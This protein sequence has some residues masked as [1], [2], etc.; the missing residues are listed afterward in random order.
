MA[1]AKLD[2]LFPNPSFKAGVISSQS[3]LVDFSPF[4]ITNLNLPQK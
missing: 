1:K 2:L 3:G 4:M